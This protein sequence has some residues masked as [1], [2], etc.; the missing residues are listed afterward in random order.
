MQSLWDDAEAREYAGD[1]AQRVYT[2]RLLGRDPT[3][4]MHGGGNTSVKLREKNLYGR[5]EDVLYV[6]GSGWN[7]ATIEAAGFAPVRLAPLLELATLPA[8]S[9]TRMANE[10]RGALTDA[11]APAPSVEAILHAILPYKFVDHTHADAVIAVTNSV[12]GRERIEEIYGERVIVVPY[13]MPG[14]KLARLCAEVFPTEATSRTVGMILLKHGVFSFG[15]TARESYERMIDLVSRAEDYLKR[16]DAWQ[17]TFPHAS[18]P[19]R[20]LR[21][22]LAALRHELSSAAGFPLIMATHSDDQALGFA[23][24]EDV[25]DIVA[26][27]TADAGSRTV[28]QANSTAWARRGGVCRSVS[29]LFRRQRGAG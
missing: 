16:H 13:V 7:L 1:L 17:I 21:E 24:R 15:E 22:E 8:L 10:L 14:F 26:A 4:V 19:E 27:G 3:L 29:R 28:H 18:A 23:R 9:D 6:K 20:P 5:D 25:G 12:N 11:S 2:S